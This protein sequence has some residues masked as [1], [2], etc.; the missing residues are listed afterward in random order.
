[1]GA[2]KIL[3]II[4]AILGILSVAL[5]HLLPELFCFWRIDGGQAFSIYLGG[6]GFSSGWF[7][8][9][10]IPPEYAED[11]MLLIISVLIIAGSVIVL[12]GGLVENKAVGILGGIIILAGP[13]LLI[14]A[15]ILEMGNFENFATLLGGSLLF[16][17]M[18]GVSWGLWIGSFLALGGG[19]LGL[20]GGAT[21]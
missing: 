7:M 3:A 14:L 17:S 13:I 6:F 20:I 11:I 2:G 12:I 19:V 5:F 1:M 15:L 10:Q 21:V 9:I 18:P 8:G 16:G 4:G